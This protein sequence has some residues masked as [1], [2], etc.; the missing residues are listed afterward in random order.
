M[1]PSLL[2]GYNKHTPFSFEQNVR[3]KVEGPDG[4]QWLDNFCDK[5]CFGEI[6]DHMLKSRAPLRTCQPPS[7]DGPCE[8]DYVWADDLHRE[9]DPA[10]NTTAIIQTCECPCQEATEKSNAA[11]N[12]MEATKQFLITEI[13]AGL[14]TLG[15]GC[16]LVAIYI[17][18]EALCHLYNSI[19]DEDEDSEKQD[20]LSD[21][22]ETSESP[23]PVP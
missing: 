12:A 14:A 4:A 8:A 13:S 9:S 22:A 23:V 21:S 10:C 15:W 2:R 11:A 17:L 6:Q 5:A 7:G 1:T 19:D 20:L 3:E 16:I 18:I